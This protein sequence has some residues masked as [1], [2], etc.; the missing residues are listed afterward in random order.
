MLAIRT[1]IEM[2]TGAFA[3]SHRDDARVGKNW[4]REFEVEDKPP[5]DCQDNITAGWDSDIGVTARVQ[6]TATH[7]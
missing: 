7:A 2:Y 4:K 3:A 6:G 5:T 1:P